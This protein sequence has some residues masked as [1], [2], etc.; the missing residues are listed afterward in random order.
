MRNIKVLSKAS[1]KHLYSI[2]HKGIETSDLPFA[3][4]ATPIL[5]VLYCNVL[6]EPSFY[7]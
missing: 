4:T 3:L 1:F 5:S 7:I 6:K 2:P